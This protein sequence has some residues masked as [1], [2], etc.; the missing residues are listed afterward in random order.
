MKYSQTYIKQSSVGT[1]G[2]IYEHIAVNSIISSLYS[3]G[4]Y[5]LL[6]YELDAN[7][8]DGIV[9]VRIETHNRTLLLRIVAMLKNTEVKKIDVKNALGQIESEYKRKSEFD[10][11]KLMA[12]LQKLNEQ[13]WVSLRHFELTNSI[14]KDSRELTSSIGGFNRSAKRDFKTYEIIHEIEDCP[15]EL[16]TIAVYVLQALGFMYIDGLTEKTKHSYDASDE[17]AEYQDLVGYLHNLT[18]PKL[19]SVTDSSIEKIIVNI[20][21]MIMKD[22]KIVKKIKKY[23]SRNIKAEFPYFSLSSIFAKSYQIAGSKYTETLNSDENILFVLKK[24]THTINS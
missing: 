13:K 7:T 24:I 8:Y 23:I 5:R 20:D 10:T 19:G 11:K 12:E 18:V 22:K 6:D 21:Q 9:V 4:T 3:K 2:H 1:V 15:Y 16:K 14:T 17:W